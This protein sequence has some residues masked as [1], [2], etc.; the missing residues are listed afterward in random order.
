MQ[1]V[2]N[3]HAYPGSTGLKV[4]QQWVSVINTFP[5]NF[6]IRYVSVKGLAGRNCSGGTKE[7]AQSAPTLKTL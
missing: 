7:R 3:Q 2:R 1:Y 5:R 4:T 6:P